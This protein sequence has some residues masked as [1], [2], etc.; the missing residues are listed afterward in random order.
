MLHSQGNKGWVSLIDG[1][2]TTESS[3]SFLKTS[4]RF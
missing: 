3:S 4:G 1:V 2:M